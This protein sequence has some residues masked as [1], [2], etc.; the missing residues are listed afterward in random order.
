MDL[1]VAEELVKDMY[2]VTELIQ[3]QEYI[4]NEWLRDY[5]CKIA[6]SYLAVILHECFQANLINKEKFS[7]DVIKILSYIRQRMIKLVPKTDRMLSKNRM[8]LNNHYTEQEIK[9]C[10]HKILDTIS[11]KS[12]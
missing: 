11:I 5:Y 12:F 9:K 4:E 10:L 1:N 7:K 6:I 2:F 8:Q 3:I